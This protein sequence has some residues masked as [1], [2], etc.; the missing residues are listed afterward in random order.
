[1]LDQ[2]V[3]L[4]ALLINMRRS[5]QKT[6]PAEPEGTLTE[7]HNHPDAPDSVLVRRA[8]TDDGFAESV[9]YRR[10]APGILKLACCLLGDSQEADDVVQ[11]TFVTAFER[12]GQLRHDRAFA[13]WLRQIA[14]RQIR[15]RFRRRR[16]LNLLGFTRIEDD[17]L[18]QD[19]ARSDTGAQIR[20]VEDKIRALPDRSRIA[21]VMHR[22][23]A[24]SLRETADALKCSMSTVKRA[25]AETDAVL[26]KHYRDDKTEE[27]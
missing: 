16:L 11:D 12:L 17:T 2:S 7:L 18:I 25:I 21:W 22:V 10:H 5:S 14:V 19:A 3:E 4:V 26:E 23:E 13:E 8:R 27:A 20:E 1:M 6:F 15:R 9:L 24:Y